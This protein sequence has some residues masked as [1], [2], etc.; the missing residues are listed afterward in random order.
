MKYF[1]L[2][3]P[4]LTILLAACTQTATVPSDFA[5]EERL[6][7]LYPDYPGVTVP[8]NIAPLNFAIEEEADDYV[9]RFTTRQG[10][11]VIGGQSVLIDPSD[12]QAMKQDGDIKVEVFCAKDSKWTLLK[13]FTIHVSGDSID[14]YISYRLISPSYVTYE[15]L[16]LNQRCLENFDESLLYGNM[17]NTN[18]QNGQCINCHNY[19][20]HNPERMQFHVRQHKGGT[21]ICYDGK[22]EKVDMKYPGGISA[23]VYPAWHPTLPLI[24]YSTNR[25]GQTFHTFDTQKIEVQ[26]TYSDLILY[27]VERHEI[28]PLERDTNDLDCFPHWDPAG[29][30]LYYCSAHYEQRDSSKS[31]EM[32]LIEHYQEVHYN[33][34][35]RS[36]DAENRTFGAREL[37]Y[38]CGDSCSATL[39]RVSPDGRYLLFTLGQYGVFHIWHKSSDLYLMDLQARTTRPARELNSP[40]VES[41]HSWSSNG[42]WIIF[43]SRRYDGNFTRPFMAHLNADGTFT[44]PFEL[45]Q[46]NPR[47]HQEFLRS[48]NVPEF[49]TGPVTVRPQQLA[50]VVAGDSVKATLSPKS[51]IQPDAVTAATSQAS[52]E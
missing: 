23:G 36:F 46:E 8:C 45:P 30:Y 44:R 38:D 7:T 4:L 34:Y 28:L 11:W 21:V 51:A 22:V 26:D 17:I 31:K 32:D 19:Q 12:W 33:L 9:T 5:R 14:P 42:K 29:R 50:A 20:A 13:P 6:P 3:L 24:V 49:M 48:Y 35:R 52:A 47:Y 16:T 2:L 25:T 1:K 18:E 40:D 41:Y 43:S 15:N 37:V 39:P 27:D 10:Q